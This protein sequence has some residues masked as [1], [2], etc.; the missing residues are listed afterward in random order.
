MHACLHEV[1]IKQKN[2][3]HTSMVLPNG[4]LALHRLLRVLEYC[5]KPESLEA[6][7]FAES[8]IG[9]ARTRTS[10][11]TSDNSS[12]ELLSGSKDQRSAHCSNHGMSHPVHRDLSSS[13]ALVVIHTWSTPV[14]MGISEFLQAG[15]L[16]HQALGDTIESI[17]CQA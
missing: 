10:Q 16:L 9:A 14:R 6:G 5:V 12:F 11:G 3:P 7:L 8:F 2:Q 17:T 15:C 4:L 13:L 1:W